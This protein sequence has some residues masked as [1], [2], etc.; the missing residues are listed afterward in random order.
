MEK[1]VLETELKLLT[2]HDQHEEKVK[3]ALDRC[4]FNQM[5]FH[6]FLQEL[7]DLL[8]TWKPRRHRF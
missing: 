8:P 2:V 1:S 5:L 7:H 6:S 3:L 4:L